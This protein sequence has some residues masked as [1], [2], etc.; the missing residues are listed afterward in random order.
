MKRQTLAIAAAAAGGLSWYLLI[1]NSPVALSPRTQEPPPVRGAI[2]VHT[3]RSDGTGTVEEVAAAAGRAG[4]QFVIFTDHGDGTRGSDTPVYRDGVLCIDAVEI[5]TN[6][7]HVVALDLPQAPF[8]LGG[9]VHD[10][11]D[12]VRRMGGMSIAAHPDSSRGELGWSDWNSSFDGIEWLNGDSQWRDEGWPTIAQS[13]LTYPFR[14]APTLATL[15]DRPDDLVSRWDMLL[16]ERPVVAVA[17]ADAHA[18]L[19]PG[20][21]PYGRSLSL[22]VPSYEQVFRTLSISLPEAQLHG[23]AR[24]DARVVVDAIR[25]GRVYSTVDALATPAVVTFTATD[26]SHRAAMGDYL[27]AERPVILHVGADAPGEATIRLISDGNT[28]ASGKPPELSYEAPPRAAAYRVEIDLP[29]APGMPPVPWVVSNPIYVGIG[30]VPETSTTPLSYAQ[31]AAVY[32]DGPAAGW[33]IEASVRSEATLSVARSV[34]GTQLLVRY[35]LGGTLSESPYVAAVVS[36]GSDVAR[37]RGVMFTARSLKPMRLMFEVRAN[38]DGD[39][40]WGR[41]VYLDQMER[42]VAIAFDDM[43][44]LG[45]AAGRPALA[46]VRDLLFVVDTVHAK[47]GASGQFWL[48]DIRYVR[49]AN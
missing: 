35:G 38:G 8:P 48:D 26:G 10:V 23:D 18:R 24:E 9:E 20:R 41:S 1:P 6:G 34:E 3:R 32:T 12:D 15:L 33:R 11:L 25:N 42:M 46:D 29:S 40:R 31:T 16:R 37:F 22:H 2:H 13:L 36:S 30:L 7:G 5:S 14:R 17:A 19:G 28:V 4:L 45:T 47:Q 21:D 44:P 27:P 49:E 43:M 39:R